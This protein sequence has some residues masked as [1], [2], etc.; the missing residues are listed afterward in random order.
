LLGSP[1][2]RSG[3]VAMAELGW[4]LSGFGR[5]L[6]DVATRRATLWLLA[7]GDL[8]G[9]V[10]R[11]SHTV[12]DLS[13]A[14]RSRELLHRFGIVDLPEWGHC[15]GSRKP[16]LRYVRHVLEARYLAQ[17]KS[18]VSKHLLPVPF[19]SYSGGIPP[20]FVAVLNI[21]C[22]WK[23]LVAQRA[24]ARYRAALLDLGHNSGHRTRASVQTCI[25]CGLRVR[26][27][28]VHC[29]VACKRFALVRASLV[30]VFGSSGWTQVGIATQLLGCRP[31]SAAYLD[32][33]K[34]VQTI[35]DV[36]NAFWLSH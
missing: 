13:W 12:S 33:L 1:S 18:E 9:D 26:M 23:L 35:E 32:V 31:G 3:W 16:Y 20:D 19:L 17:L 8:Y 11:A 6:L 21:T 10:F 27:P 5:A 2:W 28:G 7:P 34:L 22:E 14:F 30:P 15:G 24:L 36:E 29:L 4:R 25:G